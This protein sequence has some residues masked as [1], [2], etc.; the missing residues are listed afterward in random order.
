MNICD[1]ISNAMT[2]FDRN[3]ESGS[4]TATFSFPAALPVFD[5]HFPQMPLLP[6]VM[7]IELVR[8]AVAKALSAP[9][10]IARIKKVKFANPVHPEAPLTAEIDLGEPEG[11]KGLVNVRAKLFDGEKEA[12]RIVMALEPGSARKAA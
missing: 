4:I 3:E 5:G 11:P 9:C 12:C 6:G 2:S 8:L 1:D 7:Q 10:A